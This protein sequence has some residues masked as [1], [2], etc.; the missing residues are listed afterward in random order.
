MNYDKTIEAIRNHVDSNPN[1]VLKCLG[2]DY[3]KVDKI[4]SFL[5]AQKLQEENK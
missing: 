4:I 3:I 2:S 1:D 5:T